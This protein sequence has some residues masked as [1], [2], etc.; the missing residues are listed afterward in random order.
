MSDRILVTGATGQ[1]RKES[2][3]PSKYRRLCVKSVH[4]IR[5]PN[6]SQVTGKSETTDSS[7]GL[8]PTNALAVIVVL[9]ARCQLVGTNQ[10]ECNQ[11]RC[12][13]YPA[14][15]ILRFSAFC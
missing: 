12:Y 8:V 14:E 5:S 15:F 7:V 13:S 4:G 9:L 6:N 3:R 11:L 10:V 1:S 2:P